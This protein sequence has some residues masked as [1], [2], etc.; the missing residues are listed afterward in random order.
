M[1]HDLCGRSFIRKIN[2][3][4]INQYLAIASCIDP[5]FSQCN[6][7]P[8]VLITTVTQNSTG[9][10]TNETTI[11][12]WDISWTKTSTSTQHLIPYCVLFC[13]FL[14]FRLFVSG[15]WDKTIIGWC[16]TPE[17]QCYYSVVFLYESDHVH[18]SAVKNF[19]H[20]GHRWF[21]TGGSRLCNNLS[22]SAICPCH[23]KI[24]WVHLCTKNTYTFCVWFSC[25]RFISD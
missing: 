9:M 17:V 3:T 16:I 4:H 13:S 18:S 12:M 11:W 21:L 19:A 22:A 25:T 15:W 5:C 8:R 2:K 7:N 1:K 20:C 23:S 24:T 14:F 6:S 10:Y